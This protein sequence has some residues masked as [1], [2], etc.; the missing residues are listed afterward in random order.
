MVLLVLSIGLLS[1]EIYALKNGNEFIVSNILQLSDGD[2]SP[3]LPIPAESDDS[4]TGAGLQDGDGSTPDP[5]PA[6]ADQ[7]GQI[8]LGSFRWTY[9]WITYENDFAGPQNTPVLHWETGATIAN[10]RADFY[11]S[12]SIEGTGVLTDGRMINLYGDCPFDPSKKCFFEV[13]TSKFPYGVGWN[14]NP[15]HPFISV[16]SD[17]SVVGPYTHLYIPALDGKTMPNG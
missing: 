8:L 3:S 17:H 13:D 16:A 5:A 2:Q 6:G 1:Y 10:V 11:T 15:L 12:V 7:N 4:E 14:D 9:Y